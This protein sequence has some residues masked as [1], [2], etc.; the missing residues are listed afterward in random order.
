MPSTSPRGIPSPADRFAEAVGKLEQALA[1]GVHADI[2]D[3]MMALG[4]TSWDLA[5]GIEAALRQLV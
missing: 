2:H 1:K 5:P 3:A 4:R